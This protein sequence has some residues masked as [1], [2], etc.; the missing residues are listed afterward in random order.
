MKGE[1]DNFGGSYNKLCKKDPFSL[2]SYTFLRAGSTAGGAGAEYRA[3][4][5]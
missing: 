4:K 3:F 5:S 2:R 1:E